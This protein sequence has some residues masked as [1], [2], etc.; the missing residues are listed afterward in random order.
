MTHILDFHYGS[1]LFNRDFVYVTCFELR[2]P[3][4]ETMIYSDIITA[5]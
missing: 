1:I 3:T 4:D 2:R 5:N